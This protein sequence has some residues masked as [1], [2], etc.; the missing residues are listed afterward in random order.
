MITVDEIR[1]ER[2]EV[3][4]NDTARTTRTVNGGTEVVTDPVTGEVITSRPATVVTTEPAGVRQDHYESV[5]GDPYA[6]RRHQVYR[7][8]QAVYLI[9]GIIQGLLALRFVL[10][11]LGANPQAGFASFIYGITAP[12]MA[13]FAGLFG[14]PQMAGSVIE[15]NALV[16]I[17]VYALI[18]WVIAK[19]VWIVAGDSRQS[20]VTKSQHI[21]QR[22]DR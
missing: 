7:I 2:T 1:N 21:D 8:Q 12:F 18:A 17:A 11:L 10:R 5:T 15:W 6:A 22:I 4:Q 16:A 9:F 19:V 13:P 3:V 20:L 14:N